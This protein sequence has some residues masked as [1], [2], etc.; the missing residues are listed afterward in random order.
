LTWLKQTLLCMNVDIRK[1]QYDQYK[2]QREILKHVRGPRTQEEIDQSDGTLSFNTWSKGT[3]N[4]AD[5][6]EVTS[7]PSSS[8]A[9]GKQ[10]M[11]QQHVE[12][13]ESEEDESNEDDHDDDD[14]SEDSEDAE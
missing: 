9:R 5:F 2:T 1:T 11:E 8:D 14:A 13:D 7:R 10:P 6:V 3:V 12:E 4:W